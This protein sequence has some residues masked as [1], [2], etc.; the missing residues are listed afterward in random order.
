[1]A[2]N[3]A[4]GGPRTGAAAGVAHQPGRSQ[5]RVGAHRDRGLLDVRVDRRA[6]KLFAGAERR[7]ELDAERQLRSA[8][9]IAERLGHMKGALMKVGQM[10]SYLDDGLPEPVRLALAE[11]QSNAPPMSAELA[12]GV[13]EQE[14]GMPPEKLFVEWDPRADRGRLDRP[15]AP[16]G[17]AR[18][19]D[20]RTSVPSR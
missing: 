6:R 3:A 13:V 4:C 5:R 10:A 14:L 18:P 19:G 1:M 20:G 9:Q 7:V 15:G 8:E 12:A 17:V 11:L 16:R 2:G